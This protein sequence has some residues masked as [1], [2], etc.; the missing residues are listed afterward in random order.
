MLKMEEDSVEF[1]LNADCSVVEK[2]L[3]LAKDGLQ[4]AKT[5]AQKTQLNSL[6]RQLTQQV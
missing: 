3:R 1:I 5:D 6:I 4:Y 2:K